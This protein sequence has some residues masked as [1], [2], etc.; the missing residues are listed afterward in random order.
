MLSSAKY[1]RRT[2]LRRRN[3]SSLPAIVCVAV[4]RSEMD[5]G[6]RCYTDCYINAINVFCLLFCK[7]RSFPRYSRV[8]EKMR[9]LSIRVRSISACLIAFPF[10]KSARRCI[11]C[12]GILLLAHT[13]LQ[14]QDYRATLF[15][16]VTDPSGAVIS[17]GTVRATNIDTKEV[18][19]AQTTMDGSYTIPYL[20]PG[21]Y[22]VEVTAK[23]FRPLRREKIVIQVADKLN[24]PFKLQVGAMT[25]NVIV[26]AG[27]EVLETGSADRGLVFDPIK[28]QEFPLNGRQTYMLM[29]LTPG[30]LFTQ[31]TF[32]PSG[33][34]GTRGWDVNNSYKI[35]GA[36]AGQNTFLLNGA[37]ISDNN[38]T[39][40]LA[41]NVEAVQEFKVMTNTY[42][43]QYG[44]FGGGV[45]NTT[46]KSGTSKWHGDV[47][48]YFRNRIFDANYWQNNYVGKPLQAHNQ[49]QFGGVVGGPIRKDRDFIFASFE[50]WREIIG[51]PALSSV[52][53]M[54][55]R[56]IDP[57]ALG[58]GQGGINFGVLGYKI[59]DPMTTHPCGGPG[60]PC[61]TAPFWRTQFP[62]NILPADRINA[63]G[64]KILSYFPVPN[65]PGLMNNFVAA[66]NVGRYQYNQPM[67][68]WDHIFS[69]RD[70][71]YALATFQHGQEYRNSTGFPAP[72]GSGDVGSQRTDQ[73]YIA[74]WT[75]VL[76][77]TA[78]VDVRGSYGRFTQDFPRYTDFGLTADKIG[79]AQAFH[80]PTFKKNTV[81]HI[82]VGGYSE[83]FA[84]CG[85]VEA[86]STFNQ[87]DFAPSLTVTSGKHTRHFGFEYNYLASGD[88]N[89]GYSNGSFDF[90][91]FW[92]QQNSSQNRGQFDGS[93]LAT[94]LLGAPT[95]GY[96]NWNESAYRT[97][98]YFGVYA[99]D[100]WRVSQRLTLNLG[101][102]YEVQVPWLERFNRANRG[103]DLSSKNPYSD[104]VLA[105]WAAMRADWTACAGG[106][107]PRCPAG[108]SPATASKYPYPA[109]PAML[110]GGYIFPGVG[111]QP[112]RL[113]DTDWTTIAPRLGIAWLV[114]PKTVLR[115]GAG[116]Y[117]QSPTQN[118]TRE[119]FTQSTGYITSLNGQT[120][121]AC[122]ADP[123]TC[124]T[125]AYSLATPFPQGIEPP[126]G[127]GL[128]LTTDVGNGIGYDPSHFRIP[129]T[130]QYSFGFERELPHMILAEVSYAGNYQVHVNTSFNSGHWSLADNAQ[131][132]ND[133]TYLNLR[134]PNPFYGIIPVRGIG[135]T[136]T[137][138]RSN[139]LRPDPIF[140]DIT[141]FLVQDGHYRS[142]ALQVKLEQRVPG[143]KT[144]G[145]L[146]WGVS[147]TFSKAFEANH[148]LN[149]WNASEPL[150][151]ELD[152]TDK[153]HVLAF[154]G[155]WDL[156]GAG[157]KNP[158]SNGLLDNWRFDW[159]F[160]Y[161]SG[162][163]VPWPNLI[164]TCGTWVAARQDE[165][166]WFNNDRNCY[167]ANPFFPQFTPRRIPDR[168][169]N[170]RNPSKPQLNVAM[171]KTFPIG[172]R[173]RFQL[174]AEA[175]NVSN[176]PIRPGP[177]TGWCD[178][179]QSTCNFG[180][181]PKRQQNFPRVMQIAGKIYF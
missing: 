145:V 152:N 98:P 80:A 16:Q 180:K 181:L 161:A 55:L 137:F 86:W 73:N 58:P 25:E 97:R 109:P 54:A 82:A 68:R 84:C 93:G 15:G 162:N 116:I 148:R 99:Q 62:G 45:V 173:Y 110:V 26:T 127:S 156:P 21:V 163:P 31:E 12:L 114:F 19:S 30:V 72:A 35:N 176:T 117:Y 32:G 118:G 149:N 33:F 111:G 134:M 13:F 164:N 63:N 70:K 57:N 153:P 17:R 91:Q 69:D 1:T 56:T 159:I 147:Y 139:L 42:D 178:A 60:E 112:R 115:A 4:L 168:F 121:S 154:N 7:T 103:F 83:L 100:D 158:V 77:P 172:E 6:W 142:D 11:L 113:Y 65:A 129:R 140:P 87:W 166:H 64:M 123:V 88:D 151:H 36:R 144:S 157:L 141:D 124:T 43:A 89:Y 90:G 47:F 53:P 46:L 126:P 52:P 119:G 85:T 2:R 49:H 108:T 133:N 41:P 177:D 8:E 18:K 101:L 160:S 79:I 94:L 138:S 24:L 175:F 106:A 102:R 28:T 67:T 146:T 10:Q 51:F 155:V 96:V 29:S 132:V 143:G 9:N 71:L 128:G 135:N 27:Q 34:S 14:A 167:P 107:L 169:A 61:A 74:A 174:R 3:F 5:S 120:P 165:N 81:P 104:A 136:A 171:E 40:Q 38:G 39:W 78:V 95:G 125:G 170:I 150:I 48:E 92:T 23:G 22:D 105:N 20:D 44:R 59:Y 50:G 66:G 179:S 76:S 130:Y 37:P 122:G 75:H 131:G